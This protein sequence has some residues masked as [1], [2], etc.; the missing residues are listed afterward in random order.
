MKIL[1]IGS[2]DLSGKTVGGQLEKTRLFYLALRS[3]KKFSVCFINMAAQKKS[4]IFISMVLNYFKSDAAVFIT[5]ENGTRQLLK[6]L[7]ILKKIRHKPVIFIAVGSQ[8]E[9]LASI[10]KRNKNILKNIDAAFF[11]TPQ[12]A[13]DMEKIFPGRTCCMSNCKTIK[14]FYRDYPMDETP[15]R[16]CY[17]SEI[18]KRK[19]FDT[20]IQALDRVNKETVLYELDVYGY[21]GDDQAEMKRY[22]KRSYVR[23]KKVLK[24]ENAA[25]ELSKYF[26]MLFITRHPHEGVPG[27]VVDAFEAG[28]PVISTDISYMKDIIR[29]GQTGYIL[30]TEDDLEKI[31]LKIAQNRKPVIEM[32]QNC[33]AEAYEYDISRAVNVFLQKMTEICSR[34]G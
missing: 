21:F 24:R 10:N 8:N 31:L 3:V 2:A 32:R 29:D 7:H 22:L 5:S 27:A 4:R 33:V 34:E 13:Q 19:G 18:S 6:I 26:L 11:E 20:V 15:L 17:Y 12:M 30:K 23:Y 1:L 14:T 25:S 16:I 28:L 9:A